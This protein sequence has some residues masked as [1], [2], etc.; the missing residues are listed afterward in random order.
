[1][2]KR[3][4]YALQSKRCCDCAAEIRPQQKRCDACR[5][6]HRRKTERE[7]ARARRSDPVYR[8]RHNARRRGKQVHLQ[9]RYGITSEEYAA[10]LALQDG[11]CGIC[12]TGCR[13]G[14]RLA[15]DHCHSTG[16]VRGLLCFA[17]NTAL[18]Q[19]ADDPARLRLAADWIERTYT[20]IPL[21]PHSGFTPEGS[22][23]DMEYGYR[24]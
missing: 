5:I 21:S 22:G 18:G 13:T 19:M 7:N 20:P 14:Q 6:E 2:P 1:M 15:V 10:Y 9:A 11:V 3:P 23:E 4:K 17:C 16:R 8:E 24:I 12:G